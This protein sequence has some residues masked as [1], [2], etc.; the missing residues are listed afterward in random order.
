MLRK[1]PAVMMINLW[2]GKSFFPSTL[3]LMGSLCTLFQ[4]KPLFTQKAQI[5]GPKGRRQFI[6]NVMKNTELDLFSLNRHTALG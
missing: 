6:H 2:K 1:P 5:D 4:I 3:I